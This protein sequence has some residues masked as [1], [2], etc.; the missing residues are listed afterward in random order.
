MVAAAAG[1]DAVDPLR[2]ALHGG[3]AHAAVTDVATARALLGE[4][5]PS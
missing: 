5:P 3:L 2:A 4:D 1:A